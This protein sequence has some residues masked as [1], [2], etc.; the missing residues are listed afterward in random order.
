MNFQKVDQILR[1][2]RTGERTKAEVRRC[3]CDE[4]REALRRLKRHGMGLESLNIS[5]EDI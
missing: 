3:G 5:K 1:S 2:L 4:C